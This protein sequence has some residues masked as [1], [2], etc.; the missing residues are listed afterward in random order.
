MIFIL[1]SGCS[2]RGEL[3]TIIIISTFYPLTSMSHFRSIFMLIKIMLAKLIK[4]VNSI[5][6]KA[7]A[8]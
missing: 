4:V 1:V 7:T 6:Q 3:A 5:V 8:S 2:L